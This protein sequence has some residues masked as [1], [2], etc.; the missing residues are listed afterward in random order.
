MIASAM[1]GV[2]VVAIESIDVAAY[3]V[4]TD[5]PE[6]DGTLPPRLDGGQRVSLPA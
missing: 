6:R 1:T 2:D 4:P 3:T 5:A